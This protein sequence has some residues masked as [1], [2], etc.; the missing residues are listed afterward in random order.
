MTEIVDRISK[1]DKFLFLYWTDVLLK[2]IR[3]CL[4]RIL[5]NAA[6]FGQRA[7]DWCGVCVCDW[8][9][10]VIQNALQKNIL[11]FVDRVGSR[12]RAFRY[13][14]TISTSTHGSTIL[15]SWRVI[16]PFSPAQNSGHIRSASNFIIHRDINQLDFGLFY[17][18][19]SYILIHFHGYSKYLWPCWKLFLESRSR[20]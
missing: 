12:Q 17:H 20:V 6:V 15:I 11:I 16:H 18:H 19:S 13:K 3:L 10:Y 2:V 8:L 1:K 14:A 5:K 4:K 9:L 7:P